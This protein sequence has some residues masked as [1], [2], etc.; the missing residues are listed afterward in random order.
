MNITEI[1]PMREEELMRRYHL[2]RLCARVLAAQALSVDDM[3]ALFQPPALADPLTAQGMKEVIARIQ[4]A[5]DRHEKVM[6]CGDYDADGICATAIMVDALRRFGLECG[7][8][9]PNRFNEGYG[10]HA[11]TVELAAQK[12]YALLITV[13]NGVRAHEA[14]Q[15][16]KELGIEVIVT[17]HHAIDESCPPQCTI[18]LHPFLMGKPFETLSGA[19][20]ALEVSRAL[21]TENERQIV[22]AGIAAI[23]DVME[24]RQETRNIVRQCIAILNE[25][26][27]RC[28]QLLAN[29]SSPWDETKIAFQIV[30]KLNVTGR[31]AD[32]ANANNTV[33][34][35]LS[36]NGALLMNMAAQIS[37]LN[38]LRK[39]MSEQ[40]SRTAM[41]KADHSRAFLVI[42]DP[43]FHEGIVGLVAGKL[44]EQFD[45][46]CM[47]LAQKGSQCRGSIRAPKGMDLT[48]FFDELDCLQEYGGHAQ[49]AGIGFAMEDLPKVIQYA[50]QKLRE[51]PIQQQP[52][53]TL[54]PVSEDMLT[55]NEVRSLDVLRPFGNGFEEPLF[56]IQ[57][58][59]ITDSRTLSN[60][61]HMKWRTASGMELLY[62]N[63]GARMQE[64]KNGDFDTFV[65]TIG[66][67]S[68]RGRRTVNVIVKDVIK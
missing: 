6:V 36:D 50:Q 3:Q 66:I 43:S 7:F 25:K 38:A 65:G 55:L 68:F 4:L 29:D 61:K 2:S 32:K 60:D 62:F 30:P 23:G 19:G 24:M 16:A 17:D 15:K 57:R 8:Y 53:Q 10:L 47:V 37:D 56:C 18:L 42:C 64:L 28:I 41:E 33:R 11:H 46:P 14:L 44:C 52:E 13:D 67:N 59:H 22:L 26:K 9:I 45:K 31:L 48:S 21:G 63:P 12:R 51:R 1:D 58:P 5:R 34:Y 39:T 40:M 20:T 49:A 35:L 27:V 54:L